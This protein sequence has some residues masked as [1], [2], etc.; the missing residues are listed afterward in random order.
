MQGESL[1]TIAELWGS[2]PMYSVGCEPHEI[3]QEDLQTCSCLS[4]RA[5]IRCLA[6]D[7]APGGRAR[8]LDMEYFRGSFLL[9]LHGCTMEL[10]PEELDDPDWGWVRG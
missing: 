10:T 2:P 5:M 1:D 8:L 9:G 7:V 3:A 4:C 6:A